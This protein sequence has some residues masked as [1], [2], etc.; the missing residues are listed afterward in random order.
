[1][2]LIADVSIGDQSLSRQRHQLLDCLDK[3]WPSPIETSAIK[4]M[5]HEDGSVTIPNTELTTNHVT[6]EHFNSDPISNPVDDV[7][8][9]NN[10][11]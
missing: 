3:D 11:D 9:N 1:M 8:I 5:V 10:I 6:P 7:A 4:D 2:S